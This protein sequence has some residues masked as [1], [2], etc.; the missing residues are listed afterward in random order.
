MHDF[1]GQASSC[2]AWVPSYTAQHALQT[3]SCIMNHR[4]YVRGSLTF[5]PVRITA[6]DRRVSHMPPFSDLSREGLL[7]AGSHNARTSSL[8]QPA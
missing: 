5:P 3:R 6:L 1:V 8:L 7:G 2:A 4:G